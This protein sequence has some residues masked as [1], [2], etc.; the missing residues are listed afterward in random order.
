MQIYPKRWDTT[1]TAAPWSTPPASE[2]TAGSG[3]LLGSQASDPQWRP[4]RKVAKKSAECRSPR[5]MSKEQQILKSKALKI[6][7]WNPPTI[8]KSYLGSS[9]Q[10]TRKP[11]RRTWL[12]PHPI[13]APLPESELC[14]RR[15]WSGHRRRW[16]ACRKWQWRVADSWRGPWALRW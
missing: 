16:R 11:D 8:R 13:R 4:R 3:S 9:M 1:W 12:Q 10:T 6:L 7:F 2:C 5:Q 15:R 14:R